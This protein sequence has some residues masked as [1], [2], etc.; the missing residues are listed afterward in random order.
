VLVCS[1]ASLP[2]GGGGLPFYISRVGPYSGTCILLDRER[3]GG[4]ERD[5]LPRLSW[6]V[7]RRVMCNRTLGMASFVTL[8]PVVSPSLMSL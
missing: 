4:R 3:E 6:W 8:P 2:E 1:C 7:L 5:L